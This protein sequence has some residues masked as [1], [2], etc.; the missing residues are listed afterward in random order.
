MMYSL[1]DEGENPVSMKKTRL[2]VKME[3]GSGALGNRK[4][5]PACRRC[6]L[7][8]KCLRSQ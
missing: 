8:G 3:A 5:G 4:N 2:R 7:H 1:R 6:Q